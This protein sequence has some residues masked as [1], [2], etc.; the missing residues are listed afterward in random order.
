MWKSGHQSYYSDSGS[1]RDRFL[2]DNGF[3]DSDSDSDDGGGL[4]AELEGLRLTELRR[5]AVEA[6]VATG[7]VDDALDADDPRAVLVMLLLERHAV[8]QAV[9]EAAEAR[10]AAATAEQAAAQAREGRAD[11]LVP[12]T[13]LC[14]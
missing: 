1:S 13:R 10:K 3:L 8:A 5:R 4:R 11:V 7:M 12:A 9:L 6:G 14:G 2:E